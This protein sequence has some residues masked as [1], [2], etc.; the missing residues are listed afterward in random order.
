MDAIAQVAFEV[1]R[2]MDNIGARRLHTIV[3]KIL[4]EL[5]FDAPDWARDE[6]R[7]LREEKGERPEVVRFTVDKAYVEAKV[8]HLLETSDVSKFIL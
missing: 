4:E 6:R 2:T 3:E 5:S 1:N 8:R 7:R